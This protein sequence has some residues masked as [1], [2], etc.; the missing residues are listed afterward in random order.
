MTTSLFTQIKSQITARQAAE[1]YGVAVNRSGMACCVFHDD[2]HPSMKVDERFYCFSCHATGDVIDF[3]AK[4]FGLSLY[5]AAKKLA[6]DFGLRP[7]PPGQSAVLPKISP[8]LSQRKETMEALRVLT[9]Y[10]QLLKQWKEEFAPAAP[11]AEVWDQRFCQAV[12]HLPLVSHAVDCLF[13]P[14]PNER[15]GMMDSLKSAG[16]LPKV[17]AFLRNHSEGFVTR[18]A[19]TA[20]EPD[21][22]RQPQAPAERAMEVE[23][24]RATQENHEEV[25]HHTKTN[26]PAA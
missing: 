18:N 12:R 5:E 20:R 22:T 10:E 17:E 14:D 1:R 25:T 16:V 4:L 26:D 2:R 8:A 11:D 19:A 7:L 21:S 6:A 13:S 9:D 24:E 15:K 3:T 23:A